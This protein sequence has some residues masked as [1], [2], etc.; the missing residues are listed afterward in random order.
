MAGK[1][2]IVTTLYG[3]ENYF[4]AEKRV[5]SKAV[6]VKPGSYFIYGNS[7]GV[8]D[9]INISKTEGKTG[10]WVYRSEN[11]APEKYEVLTTIYGYEN[12]FDAE[13]GGLGGSQR[14]SPGSYYIFGKAAGR[15][16]LFNI[17]KTPGRKGIWINSKDNQEPEKYKLLCAVKGYENFFDAEQGNDKYETLPAGD[18]YVFGRAAGDPNLINVTRTPGVVGMWIHGSDNVSRETYEVKVLMRAYKSYHDCEVYNDSGYTDLNPGTYYVF[19]KSAGR[20][21]LYNLTEL[22]GVVGKWVDTTKNE[23]KEPDKCHVYEDTTAWI[24]TEYAYANDVKRGFSI[25]AGDYY[26]LFY[27]EDKELAY[28]SYLTQPMG[29]GIWVRSE[30]LKKSQE[31]PHKIKVNLPMEGYR[32]VEDAVRNNP[33]SAEVKVEAGEYYCLKEYNGGDIALVSKQPKGAAA[34]FINVAANEGNADMDNSDGTGKDQDA[35][36]SNTGTTS[37]IDNKPK[38]SGSLTGKDPSKTY[39]A[40]TYECPPCF[41][42]NLVTGTT[43]EFRSGMPT[44]LS[45]S[46]NANFDP[47]EIRG[48]SNQ[49]HGYNNTEARTVSFSYTF[50]ED[51]EPEGLLTIIARIKALE[52]PGYASVVEP[53][54]CYLRLGDA[55]R[56]TFICTSAPVSYG[57]TSG[58]RDGYYL[59]ADVSF[60]FTEANDYARS[61]AEVEDGGGMIE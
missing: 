33:E 11:K 34:H 24:L 18:Y 23:I 53:P 31:H 54:K 39:S 45:D 8:P 48:R 38:K 37:G 5:L 15:P 58:S 19:G 20:P 25:S 57:E 36:P 55:V 26:I 6:D 51:I 3:Y 7:A 52:Y 14:V 46:A 49:I 21:E 43:I 4:D 27:S 9:L 56:G 13:K 41:V 16:E 47:A 44:D 59:S 2:D 50:L 61:A 60:E 42:K 1:I 32:S 28:I 40:G 22:P 35:D 29:P 10:W 17:T 30:V 12:Y